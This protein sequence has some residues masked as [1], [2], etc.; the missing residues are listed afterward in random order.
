MVF[1]SIHNFKL[2]ELSFYR[3][4]KLKILILIN[5]KMRIIKKKYLTCIINLREIYINKNNITEIKFNTFESLTN[6]II[7]NLENN[8]IPKI[9]KDAF[10][11]LTKLNNL[12][13]SYNHIIF[14]K[15]HFIIYQI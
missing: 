7:I 9:D 14:K 13:L 6:L 5:L 11:W 8:N 10:K 2:E 3:N 4:K 1:I 15:N 12:S